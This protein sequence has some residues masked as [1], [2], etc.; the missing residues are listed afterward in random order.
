[1][2]VNISAKFTKN[3]KLYNGLDAIA[4]ELLTEPHLVRTAVVTFRVKFDKTDYENGGAKVPTV[5]VLEFE[6]V[7]D[8]AAV[9]AKTLQRDAFKARTGN[10]MQEDLFSSQASDDEDDKG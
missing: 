3:D 2:G 6:P 1:M 5:K 10:P 4:D 7:F 8:E 9:Q